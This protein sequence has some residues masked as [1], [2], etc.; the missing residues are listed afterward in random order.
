VTS[1]QLSDAAIKLLSKAENVDGRFFMWLHYFD[2]HQQYMP[3]EGAPDFS[4]RGRRGGATKAAYDAEVWFTDKHIGRVLDFVEN[5]SWGDRTAVVV[6]ADHGEAF[7]EHG[8]SFHGGEL[9]ESLV[10]VPL[11]IYVPGM[12]AHHVPV[13]RSHIDLVPT[14]LDVMHIPVP[15]PTEVSGRSMLEDLASTDGFEE[16]DVYIDMPPGPFTG[17]RHALITGST[18]GR[19]HIH[20]GGPQFQLFDL[21]TDP[22]E[23]EDLARDKATVGP[24]IARFQEYRARLKEI[25]VKAEAATVK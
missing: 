9:W 11:L 10:R 21:T 1:K 19:K 17:M 23:Q 13:K 22:E 18:P 4:E 7:D 15:G 25:E 20:L 12:P 6:T 16:R 2:P 5:S 14:M 8:M 24:V 3:H